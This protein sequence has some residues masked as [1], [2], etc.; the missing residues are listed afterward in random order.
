MQSNNIKKME[1]ENGTYAE[2]DR[3]SGT[4][5]VAGSSA[6]VED[7]PLMTT[8][9]FVKPGVDPK[10]AAIALTEKG[11]KQVVIAAAQDTSQPTISNLLSN[12]KS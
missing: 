9:H 1:F 10:A 8:V 11:N 12:D 5:I 2:H 6:I 3:D 4:T 7:S